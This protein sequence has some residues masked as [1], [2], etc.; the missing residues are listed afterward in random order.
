MS[1]EPRIGE[2]Y[3]HLG[4]ICQAQVGYTNM[5]SLGVVYTSQI[6]WQL[7]CADYAKLRLEILIRQANL[8]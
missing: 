3:L 4:G 2:V 7:S 6:S 8:Y 5:P 1:L